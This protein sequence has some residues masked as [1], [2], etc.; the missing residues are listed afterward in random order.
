M[1]DSNPSNSGSDEPLM[2]SPATRAEWEGVPTDPDPEEDL[3]YEAADL[4]VFDADD[5]HLIYLPQDE[6]MLRDEAFIIARKADLRSL[7]E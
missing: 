1:A 6:D 2:E 4:E 7:E 5:D 3:G